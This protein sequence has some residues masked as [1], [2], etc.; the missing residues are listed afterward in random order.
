MGESKAIKYSL[1]IIAF[2]IIGLVVRLTKP[3]LFPFL[4]ALF[5]SYAIAP[6]ID[7]LIKFKVPR[8]VALVLVVTSIFAIFYLLGLLLYASAS[9]FLE[10]LPNYNSKISSLFQDLTDSLNRLPFRVDVPSIVSQLNVDKIASLLL[11]TVGSF[12]SFLGNLLLVVVF[13]IFILAGKDK[14]NRKIIMS[15][16][17]DRAHQLV[18]ILDR[19]NGQIQKYLAVKTFL[20]LL[21]G[22]LVFLILL[23]FRVDFALL[24]GFLTF[25]LN[26]IPS[27]GSVIATIIPTAVAFLQFGNSMVPLW[28]LLSIALTDAVLGNFVDPKLMGHSLNLSPL[29]VLFS[30][31]FWA[32]LWGIAGMVLAVPILAVIKIIL[33]NVPSLK[34]WAVLMSK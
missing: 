11:G 34:P 22:V 4:L 27:F 17:E 14:L 21:N 32:W 2:F 15:F 28:V 12:F 3:V 16:P 5:I 19:I 26:F 25:V 10:A 33:E 29:L 6:V 30:L 1:L 13:M 20:S 7:G 23:I 8:V 9:S 18:R 31:V 24:L